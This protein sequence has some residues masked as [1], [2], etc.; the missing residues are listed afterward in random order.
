MIIAGLFDGGGI[1]DVRSADGA[2]IVI[3]DECVEGWK[4]VAFKG[5][6]S[7]DE[8]VTGVV[9]MEYDICHMSRFCFISNL[10]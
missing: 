2:E 4:M 7:T 9:S 8:I 6:P 3:K 10:M 5:N 1:D